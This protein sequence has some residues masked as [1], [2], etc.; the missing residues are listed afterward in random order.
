VVTSD[1]GAFNYD[2]VAAMPLVVDTRNALRRFDRT[3]IFRL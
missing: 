1:H 3:S 2:E